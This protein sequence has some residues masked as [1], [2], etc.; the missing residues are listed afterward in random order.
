MVGFAL[1]ITLGCVVILRLPHIP[2]LGALSVLVPIA[3]F[4]ITRPPLR[5]LSGFV[6]GGWLSA[7]VITHEM[8]LRIS[9]G[10]P[11]TREVTGV[12]TGLPV[13]SDSIHRF[14][15][16]V[17]EGELTGR[18]LR[19]SW[20]APELD[21]VPGQRWLLPVRIRAPTGSLNFG[22]F[23]YEG[24]LFLKRIHGTGYVLT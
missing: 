10:A 12:V 1:S 15:F 11:V 19:L 23:D 21:L 16:T 24:W 3:I 9:P 22:I 17:L 18:Q 13:I 2:D 5:H 14:Q 8:V 7:S 4:G 6:L 20:R